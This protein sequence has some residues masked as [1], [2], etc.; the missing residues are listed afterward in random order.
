MARRLSREGAT[1]QNPEDMASYTQER[2]ATVE[3][4]SCRASTVTPVV[5]ADVSGPVF[6]EL[7]NVLGI[8]I[9][10]TSL[11]HEPP[12]AG[13]TEIATIVSILADS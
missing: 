9:E 1:L 10:R 6:D 7:E 13:M 8:P 3:N 5:S 4:V 11:D 12:A 2:V